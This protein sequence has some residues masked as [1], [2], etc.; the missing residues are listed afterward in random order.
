MKELVCRD[1]VDFHFYVDDTHLCL[2][3][4]IKLLDNFI[5]YHKIWVAQIFNKIK[6]LVKVKVLLHGVAKMDNCLN[7]EKPD[8]AVIQ[9]CFTNL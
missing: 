2:S 4:Q 9:S 5:N 6:A 7:F 8:K 3:D 1:N